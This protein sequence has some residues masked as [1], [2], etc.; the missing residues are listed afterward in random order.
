MASEKQFNVFNTNNNIVKSY[1]KKQSAIDYAS[2]YDGFYVTRIK[3]GEVIYKNNDASI[4]N[5]QNN[6]NKKEFIPPTIEEIDNKDIENKINEDD[7]EEEEEE[8]LEEVRRM[9]SIN[10]TKV[11][12]R[13]NLLERIIDFIFRK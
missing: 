6:I 9:Y 13:K 8:I 2:K 1:V 7:I 4:L 3:T 5:K 11:F 10:D 12:R